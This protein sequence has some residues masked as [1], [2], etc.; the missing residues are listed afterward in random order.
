M[1]KD[2]TKLP[3]DRAPDGSAEPAA[4]AES[5]L[6]STRRRFLGGMAA[7][8]VAL[9]LVSGGTLLGKSTPAKA[10]GPGNL[11]GKL[12]MP[13]SPAAR[14]I[15]AFRVR[16]SAALHNFQKPIVDHP[17]NGD[18]KNLSP[19]GL[20]SFHKSLP[21]NSLGEV[22][23]GDYLLLLRAIQ[24]GTDTAYDAVPLGGGRR[25]V[26]PQAG[27]AFDLEGPDAAATFIPPSP[28]FSSPWR[29]GEMVEHYWQALLRD[30]AFDAYATNPVAQAAI[31]DLNQLSDFRG[32]REAG[33]VTAQTLFR[34]PLP[35][36]TVGPYIS[37]FFLLPVGFGA[38]TI[39]QR[40]T[41]GLSNVDYMT[42]Y[43]DWLDVQNG[44]NTP[45]IAVAGPPRF[46]NDGRALSQF[47]HI[48][49]LYQAYFNAMLICLGTGVPWNPGNPYGQTPEGGAG[50][51]LPFGVP[52]ALTRV[53]FAT[54]GGPYILALMAEVSTRVLKA[55][56]FQK[57]NVHRA[58]RPE[59][60]GGAV[61]NVVTNVAGYPVHSEVLN[62]SAVGEVFGRYGTYLLPQAFP[63]GSPNHP[64]YGSGHACVAGACVTI[65]KAF[66]DESAIIQNPVVSTLDGSGTLPYVGPAL[67]VGGEL[68][69]IAS[70]VATGRNIAGVHWRSDAVES[71]N[72]GEAVAIGVLKD[73]R[74][75]YAETFGGYTFTKFDGTTITV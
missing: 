13:Q 14:R 2:K 37:Q 4:D 5:G 46:I 64:S 51:P 34:D 17:N 48:D 33:L 10:A 53:A 67:T 49:A 43:A 9:G 7:T 31:D 21:H 12:L 42:A 68:N 73:Q 15:R 71:L 45:G 19:L 54:F 50:R 23:S 62:S 63:E 27:L 61:H 39:D 20:G 32:P 44:V 30:V 24:Q 8:P 25:L 47:A 75:L 58:L 6:K 29:A 60:F 56:W 26:N 28:A 66:F 59:A 3:A 1:S 22:S 70:N 74:G 52:G 55:Q 38:Q 65:L 35:G 16:L 72:L 11:L 36:A 18:E 41:A 69:K 57:W 40:V